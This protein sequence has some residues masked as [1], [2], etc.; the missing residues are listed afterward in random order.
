MHYEN[1]W[2]NLCYF[3]F[4]IWIWH[5]NKYVC[6]SYT[7]HYITRGLYIFNCGLYCKAVS[8]TD[9]LCT[10]QGNS[11]IFGS[12]ICG[13]K[14]RTVSNQEQVIVVRVPYIEFGQWGISARLLCNDFEQNTIECVF[15]FW[16]S[17]LNCFYI[18]VYKYAQ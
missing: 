7:R 1:N 11:L 12:E 18:F 3:H 5:K 16:N 6:I 14:L 13:L 10:K 8:V 15:L 2:G 17:K 4:L 9:N